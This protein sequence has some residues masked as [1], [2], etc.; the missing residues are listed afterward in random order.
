MQRLSTR[1]F[2]GAIGLVILTFAVPQAS[3]QTGEGWVVLLDDKDMGDWNHLGETN[4][5][6]EDGAVVADDRTSENPAYL[7][8]K[9]P[10][11]VGM[12]KDDKA[13][14]EAIDTSLENHVKDGS[15]QKAYEATLGL[16]GSA[17]IAPPAIERY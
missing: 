12:N 2:A 8:T 14:R 17:Y 5:R 4:W 10:Y 16:S 6:Q 3:G 1:L 7:V 9:E 15:Y 13:L 11:G